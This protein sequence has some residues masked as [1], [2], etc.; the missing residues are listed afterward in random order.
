MYIN[1]LREVDSKL[2][3]E[4]E[5]NHCVLSLRF[6]DG[7]VDLILHTNKLFTFRRI[8]STQFSS[9]Q[10]LFVELLNLGEVEFRFLLCYT[11]K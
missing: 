8:L 7:M 3:L 5:E 1:S 9:A 4:Y 11:E 6:L 10:Y 2:I